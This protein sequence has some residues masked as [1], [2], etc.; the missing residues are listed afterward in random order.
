VT[1]APQALIITVNFRHAECTLQLLHS[2]SRLDRFGDCRLMIVDNN[3]GDGSAERIRQAIDGFNNVEL[4]TSA[5]NRG[6]FGAAKW[7]LD[8]H[9]V[10]Q[11][12]PDWVIVCNNDIIFDSPSFL[13]GLLVHDPRAVAVL[14][15]A[16]V[17]RLTGFDANPM[18][19][20]RPGR[21]RKL[22]YRFLASTYYVAWLT[23]WLAPVVRKA[24]RRLRDGRSDRRDART[25]IYAPHGS[26]FIFSRRYFEEGGFID[27][28]C[29]LY[30]EEISVA[31]TCWRL[32]LPVIH[33][34]ELKV[35][36]NDSQTT[37]RMLTRKGYLLQREGLQYALGKY[38]ESSRGA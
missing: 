9:L 35:S 37:G 12:A 4:L 20:G 16:I 14:A 23:Q 6:Y 19:A 22:R 24:R 27:D 15:P 34:P 10:N 3:S 31:E 5:S 32:G 21:I 13:A 7:A 30:A 36:H 17:S 8:Q 2:A 33:D 18:I 28:G 38:L 26:F 25:R 29:F 1:K 11:A